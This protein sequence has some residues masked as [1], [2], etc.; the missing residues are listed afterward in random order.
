MSWSYPP[1]RTFALTFQSIF[2]IFIPQ[3]YGPS[4]SQRVV[5]SG[6]FPC[7]VCYTT[8]IELYF[9][10]EKKGVSSEENLSLGFPTRS[11]TNRVVQAQKMARLLK[12]WF[13]EVVGCYFLCALC[14]YTYE[15][16]FSPDHGTSDF[17]HLL[18]FSD[19]FFQSVK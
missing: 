4:H 1:F 6:L 5:T 19:F 2:H 3:L 16:H 10:S 8:D 13:K 11:N 12:F 17:C 9:L 7:V 14:E 15:Q 18:I